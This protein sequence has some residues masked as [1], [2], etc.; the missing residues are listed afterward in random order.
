MAELA[1]NTTVVH[2]QTRRLEEILYESGEAA[3]DERT[4]TVYVR[5][6]IAIHKRTQYHLS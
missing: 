2:S 4:T 5:R 1:Y 6:G 3:Q